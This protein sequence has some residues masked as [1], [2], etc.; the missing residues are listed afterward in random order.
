MGQREVALR[1]LAGQRLV[2]RFWLAPAGATQQERASG[3]RGSLNQG[4]KAGRQI[5]S[6]GLGIFEQ[7][8]SHSLFG[9]R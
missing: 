3:H 6:K 8:D 9:P 4:G 2:D 7:S 5:L 1:D